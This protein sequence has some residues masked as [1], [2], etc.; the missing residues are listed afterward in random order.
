M[1]NVIIIILLANGL[2]AIDATA[3]PQG[4]EQNDAAKV[5][6]AAVSSGLARSCLS[7]S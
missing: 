6:A 2:V 7:T 4:Q 5:P 3:R 1:R